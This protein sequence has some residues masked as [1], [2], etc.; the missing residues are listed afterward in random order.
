MVIEL[1]Q[2]FYTNVILKITETINDSIFYGDAP[3][4]LQ[5][6]LYKNV[7]SKNN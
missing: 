3:V 2:L 6:I 7:N 5:L 1:K 4:Y